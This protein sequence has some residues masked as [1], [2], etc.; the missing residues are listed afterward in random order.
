MVVA[1]QDVLGPVAGLAGAAI[2]D[3]LNNRFL[4][5][6]TIARD[7]LARKGPL[8]PKYF[9]NDSQLSA[10][11][12]RYTRA[13]RDQA[14][15]ENLRLLAQVMRELP[16]RHELWA[17]EFLKYA[18]ILAPLIRDELILIGRIMAFDEEWN[19]EARVKDEKPNVLHMIQNSDLVPGVFESEDH[20]LAIAGR[21][22]RSGLIIAKSGWGTLVYELSPLGRKVRS[23]VNIEDAIQRSPVS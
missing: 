5:A 20:V 14:A 4:K 8:T 13:V 15:D 9:R 7:E 16:S 22:L 18:D 21:A 17:T 3:Y 11:V 10:A 23:L 1:K 19:S 12:W 6:E 2:A